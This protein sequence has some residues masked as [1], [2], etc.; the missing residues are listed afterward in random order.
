M[1]TPHGDGYTFEAPTRYD[2]LLC[3]VAVPRP[4]F[5]PTGNQGAEHIG[6]ADTFDADYVQVLER[7]AARYQNSGKWVMTRAG[8]EPAA[9]GLK[10]RC[11]TSELPGR[12]VG[13]GDLRACYLGAT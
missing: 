9:H 12:A 11:S 10:V 5:I 1:F 8:I 3:G 13:Q 6:P 7:A 2:K 4:K